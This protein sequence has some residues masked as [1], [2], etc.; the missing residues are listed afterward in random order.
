MIV[1]PG[2]IPSDV[3]TSAANHFNISDKG[4]IFKRCMFFIGF[5]LMTYQTGS[6]D[7]LIIV[8]Q[9]LMGVVWFVILLDMTIVAKTHT[10]RIGC[11]TQ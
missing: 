2:V 1:I 5:F 7:D 4:D 8:V 6:Y 9:L 3:V 11:T 10:L